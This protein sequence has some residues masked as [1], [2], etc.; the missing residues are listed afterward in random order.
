MTP[1]GE[2]SNSQPLQGADV[3]EE[4]RKGPAGGLHSA[5]AGRRGVQQEA[6]RSFKGEEAAEV[7]GLK[8]AG[9]EGEVGPHLCSGCISAWALNTKRFLSRVVLPRKS[10][11]D[12]S[13]WCH[14]SSRNKPALE[15]WAGLVPAPTR[16]R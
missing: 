2:T 11:C 10:P 9:R 6:K 16:G 8:M 13:H 7:K 15:G 14:S 4:P 1:L 5:P 3:A 12:P